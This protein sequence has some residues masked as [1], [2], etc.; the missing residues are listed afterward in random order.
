M[1]YVRY[2]YVLLNLEKI[3]HNELRRE[4]IR[5]FGEVSYIKSGFKVFKPTSNNKYIIIRINSRHLDQ[6]F[7]TLKSLEY[8]YNVFVGP[9]YIGNTLK[10]VKSRLNDLF[11]IE[12]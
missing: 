7:Y 10:S 8:K 2:R 11:N 6:L 5:L 12:D 3:L 9:I 1:K 4:Y